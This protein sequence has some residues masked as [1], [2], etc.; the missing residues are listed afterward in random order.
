MNPKEIGRILA[1][2]DSCGAA[3]T[4]KYCRAKKWGEGMRRGAE[5]YLHRPLTD[6]EYE[7]VRVSYKK[8]LRARVELWDQI[9]SSMAASDPKYRH[10]VTQPRGDEDYPWVP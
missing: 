10:L 4:P 5:F 9:I 6:E 3:L 7:E 2:Y 8:T 1:V